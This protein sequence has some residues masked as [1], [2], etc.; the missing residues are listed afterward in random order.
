MT[1]A[2]PTRQFEVLVPAPPAQVACSAASG[3]ALVQ[4][5]VPVTT[6]PGAAVGGTPRDAALAVIRDV[7]PVD[8][9]RYAGPVGWLDE[10]GDTFD[11]IVADFPDP[12]NFSIGKLYTHSFYALLHLPGTRKGMALPYRKKNLDTNGRNQI[13]N[14][15]D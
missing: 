3:P 5:S 15:M 9:G 1:A 11:V 4:V 13:K 8:R 12:T 6:V 10:T 2:P 7:E 14:R